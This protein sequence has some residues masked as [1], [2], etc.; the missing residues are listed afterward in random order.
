VI[1][2]LPES[3]MFSRLYLT[4]GNEGKKPN[5]IAGEK[6]ALPEEGI[7]LIPNYLFHLMYG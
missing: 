6:N 4:A 2:N 3:G 5:L 1:C 7:S